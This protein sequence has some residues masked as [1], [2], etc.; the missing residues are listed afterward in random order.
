MFSWP[1]RDNCPLTR[2][3]PLLHTQFMDRGGRIVISPGQA[4]YAAFAVAALVLAE[5]ALT[6]VAGAGLRRRRQCRGRRSARRCSASFCGRGSCASSPLPSFY[7]NATFP[8][9]YCL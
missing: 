2:R 7:P 4:R 1:T 8:F 3:G 9:L 5:I 6:P